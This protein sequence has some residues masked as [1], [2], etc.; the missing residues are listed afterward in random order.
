MK[1]IKKS[2][3]CWL[4]LFLATNQVHAF[5]E[6][7]A[8]APPS[9]GDPLDGAFIPQPAPEFDQKPTAPI[10]FGIAFLG[11]TGVLYMFYKLRSESKSAS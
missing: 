10:D 1:I 5:Y 6:D 11:A 2:L 9:D 8:P 4:I 3:L 7:P